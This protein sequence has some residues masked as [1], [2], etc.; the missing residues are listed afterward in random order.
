VVGGILAAPLAGFVVRLIPARRLMIL[1]GGLVIALA[2][3]QTWQ[4]LT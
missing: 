1:V 4:L 2:G 3:Y